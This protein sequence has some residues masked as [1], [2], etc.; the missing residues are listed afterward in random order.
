MLRITIIDQNIDN[1]NKNI[2]EREV[3]M[4]NKK[5]SKRNKNLY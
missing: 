4:K 5:L 1:S 3:D 2:N